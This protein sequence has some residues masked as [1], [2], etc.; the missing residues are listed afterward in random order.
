MWSCGR[1]VGD[2]IRLQCSVASLSCHILQSRP[3]VLVRATSYLCNCFRTYVS[4]SKLEHVGVLSN[5]RIDSNYE[6]GQTFLHRIFAYRGIVLH[7]WKACVYKKTRHVTSNSKTG[8]G[9]EKSSGYN[10]PTMETYYQVLVDGR[11]NANDS[12][13]C[14]IPYLKNPGREN[15]PLDIIRGMDYVSHADVIPYTSVEHTP[16]EHDLFDKF[17]SRGK[18]QLL[19][20]KTLSKWQELNHLWLELNNV[21]VETTDN[22]RVTAIPFFLGAKSLSKPPLYWW[23][24]CIRIE[25]LESENVC[26]KLCERHWRIISD[27]TVTR[28]SGRGVV[29]R[30]PVLDHN[31]PAFQYS[32]QVYL[33]TPRGHMWGTYLFEKENGNQFE[34]CIPAF[35]LESKSNVEL[36]SNQRT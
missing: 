30:E 34:V 27:G 16:V 31:K 32:S 10:G 11:D 4:N 5:C 22:I 35:A 20:T 1:F 24:Y 15:F 36:D 7:P 2:M 13:I 21:Y 17:I 29:G 8:N 6:V 9:I 28:Q 3:A 23:R 18:N 25:N 26:V 14:D 19:G 12:A 33:C